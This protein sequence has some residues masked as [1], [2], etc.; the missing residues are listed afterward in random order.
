MLSRLADGYLRLVGWIT[1][2]GAAAAG[3]AVVLI[4]LLVC[5]EVLLRGVFGHSTLIADEMGG[6]L[7]VA[8]IYLGLAYTLDRGGFV[9]VEIA[10]KRFTGPTAALARWLILLVSTGYI[11]VMLYFMVQYVQYSYDGGIRSFNVSQTPLWLPQSLIVVGSVILLMQL[12]AYV[13]QRARNL[14]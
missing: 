11:A 14:P 13:L 6:Y 1:L 9:R 3:G 7:N 5:L 12:L 10:Y 8:V 4:M 2:A